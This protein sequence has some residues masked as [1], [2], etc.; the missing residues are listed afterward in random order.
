MGG[1]VAHWARRAVLLCGWTLMAAIL[2]LAEAAAGGWADPPPAESEAPLNPTGRDMS[3]DAPLRLDGVYLG[4]L[5]I[6]VK[7]DD[8]ILIEEQALSHLLADSLKPEMLSALLAEAPNAGASKRAGLTIVP[9]SKQGGSRA[10]G[11]EGEDRPSLLERLASLSFSGHGNAGSGETMREGMDHAPPSAAPSPAPGAMIPLTSLQRNGLDIVYNRENGEIIARPSPD[12]RPARALRFKPSPPPPPEEE[13]AKPAFVSGFLNMRAAAAYVSQSLYGDTGF[14]SPNFDFD[15]A[16][17]LGGIVIEGEASLDT[18]ASGLPGGETAYGFTRQ[19]TR[20]VYDWPSEAVRL[21]AGDIYPDAS[22]FQ[23]SAALFGI[24]M[25]R[26]FAKLQPGR[27]MRPANEKTFRLERASDVDIVVD[28]VTVRR[29]RL[30]PGIYN[31]SDLP[32]RPGANQV[33][34]VIKEDTGAVRTLDFTLVSSRVLLAPGLDEW[35]FAAG[36]EADSAQRNLSAHAPSGLFA[37]PDYDFAAPA[38]TLFYRAGVTPFLTLEANAQAS[39]DLAMA[40]GGAIVEN[41]AGIFAFDLAASAGPSRGPGIAASLSYE[42]E[43]GRGG[44]AGRSLRLSAEYVSANFASL[45]PA[46]SRG[47][48]GVSLAVMLTQSLSWGSASL[49][50][51]Y[52]ASAASGWG[53]DTW[54]IDLGF[55]REILDGASASLSLGYAE[56]D[57]SSLAGCECGAL[58]DSGFRA[59]LRLSY[60]P[61]SRSFVS[62]AGDTSQKRAH[63]SYSRSAGSGTGAWNVAAD[64][65]YGGEERAA[66]GTLSASYTGNRFELSASHSARTEGFADAGGGFAPI[67]SEERTSIRL[68]SA[69]AFADGAWAVGRPI[70]SGF[71]IVEKHPSVRGSAVTV[72]SGGTEIAS[73][74]AFGAAL[75]PDLPAFMPRSIEFDA[76]DLP[77]GYDLGADGARFVS[78]YKAGHRVMAGNGNNVTAIGILLGRDG[79]PV[80]LLAGAARKAISGADGADAAGHIE[81]F[82]N[83]KGKFGAEGLAPG[84]WLIEM[85]GG[86]GPLVYRLDIPAGTEGLYRAGTL[87]PEP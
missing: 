29:L 34:L 67:S 58:D 81:L 38:A 80:A 49:S 75:A 48:G 66:D 72:A 10:N 84:S 32:L 47:S 39:L 8:R 45:D 74:D 28:D 36:I 33:T 44:L 68:A 35:S 73:T 30:A 57:D 13:L 37:G 43:L 31:V 20:L 79:E 64:G 85:P 19:G 9:K 86:E 16:L 78:P 12:Q 2:P 5:P 82:T 63:L 55:S 77:L 17:R 76:R 87:R 51:L 70:S 40:G 7:A 25:E 18:G 83:R 52:R 1:A 26:S 61:D 53:D 56:R 6:T 46:Y 4:D 71:A 42:T 11:A 41:A 24:S 27:N 15:G 14:V 21:K 3:F 22:G 23:S 60:R 50:G 54:G 65:G 59:F 69:I 62:L